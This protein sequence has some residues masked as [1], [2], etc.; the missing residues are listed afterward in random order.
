M[1]Y[2]AL[3]FRYCI[4]VKYRYIMLPEYICIIRI[5][6]SLLLINTMILL[7]Y[8]FEILQSEEGTQDLLI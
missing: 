4:Y 8:Y 6:L 7:K 3:T 1:Y 2:Y 5:T